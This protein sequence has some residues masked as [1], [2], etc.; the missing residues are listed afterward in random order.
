MKDWLFL[1]LISLTKVTCCLSKRLGQCT[2]K[3]LVQD[4]IISLH[5]VN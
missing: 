4:K 5:A 1:N 3:T 2:W